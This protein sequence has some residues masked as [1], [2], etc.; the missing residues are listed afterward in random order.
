MKSRFILV[1]LSLCVAL[2]F[3]GCKTRKPSPDMTKADPA[4]L[5]GG[6]GG[7][8][9]GSETLDT[10]TFTPGGPD[11]NDPNN[12]GARSAGWDDV[13]RQQRGVLQ[14]IYFDYDQSG[15]RPSEREKVQKAFEYLTANPTDK[16]LL[17]GH[18]DWRGTTEY[19]LSL[20]DRRAVSVRQFLEQLGIAPDRLQTLSK[21]D[22]EAKVNGS[23]SDMTEDRRVELI[24]VK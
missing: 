5:V 23:D 9:G 2:A 6:S 12:P 17:E 1:A 11:A 7:G 8:S 24:V 13:S 15:V 3:T 4:S 19:N 18:C 20:G 14:S 10:T 22:L 21:G 16:L